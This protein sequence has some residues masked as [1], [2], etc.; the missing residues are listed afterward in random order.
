MSKTLFTLLLVT[1]CLTQLNAQVAEIPVDFETPPVTNHNGADDP[2]MWVHPTNPDSSFF[3]GTDKKIPGGMLNVYDLLGRK[4]TA[5]AV[6]K[7]INNV[8][9]RYNFPFNG[10][11]IDIITACNNSDNTIEIWKINPVGNTFTNISGN[12]SL[13]TLGNPYGW[14]MYHNVCTNKFY[15]FLNQRFNNDGTVYQFELF[16]N[17]NGGVDINL[18]RTIDNIPTLT[19]GLT[20]DDVLGNL[21]IAQ[22]DYSLWKYGANPED[23]LTRVKV[24]STSGPNLTADIEGLTIYYSNDTTGYLIAASQGNSTFAV[25]EREGD[26]TYL[27]S[28]KLVFGGVDGV[29]KCDGVEVMSYPMGGY[30]NS[31]ALIAHDYTNESPNA[32]SNY[33]M[34]PWAN[35][36][37]AMGLRIDTNCSPRTLGKDVIPKNPVL[38]ASAKII[39]TNY[40]ETSTIGLTNTF[41]YKVI[42]WSTGDTMQ[43]ITV[44]DGG[45]F[46]ASVHNYCGDT[47]TT[48][49]VTVVA[50]HCMSIHEA[51]SSNIN[52]F[53][54]PFKNFLTIQN[55]SL[56]NFTVKLFD[57]SGKLIL[58]QSLSGVK[59]D[60]DVS[61]LKQGTYLVKVFDKHI[62]LET[63]RFVKV[64]N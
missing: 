46:H 9:V 4:I 59:T 12:N 20:V 28:F 40:G 31:G 54:N 16:D 50:D 19:E 6:G 1:Y 51:S 47:L 39:C 48:N 32:Y 42:Q 25:Y 2:S 45:N 17:G 23:D 22:E 62:L 36:A 38:N 63:K 5:L 55:N 35:I 58:N 52:I 37:N 15:G 53:P 33:K 27:G 57:V 29:D 21:Y 7:A 60:I 26:N 64:S 10:E 8:D 14:K 41:D 18:V 44:Y 30:F 3:L 49:I 56:D 61:S 43:T 34:V 11:L 13:G 24:D